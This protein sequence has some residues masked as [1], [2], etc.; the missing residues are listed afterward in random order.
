MKDVFLAAIEAENETLE[1][2][3]KAGGTPYDTDL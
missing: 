1:Q 3:L 2:N